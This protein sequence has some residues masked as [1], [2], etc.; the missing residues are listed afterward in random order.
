MRRPRPTRN[1]LVVPS[2]AATEQFT[3]ANIRRGWPARVPVNGIPHD[4][5]VLDADE[6]PVDVC[7]EVWEAVAREGA[8]G[9]IRLELLP[10]SDPPSLT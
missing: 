9:R 5:R 6:N 10:R 3:N 7:L 8:T 1:V 2:S 4:Y